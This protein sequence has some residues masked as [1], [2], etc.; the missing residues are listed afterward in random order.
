[1]DVCQNIVG[2]PSG[3][4]SLKALI[5][6]WGDGNG[7]FHNIFMENTNGDV[8]KSPMG[9]AGD[10]GWQELTTGIIHVSDRQLLIGGQ[11]DYNAHYTGFR[12]LFYGEEPPVESLIKQEI[13]EVKEASESLT[14]EGD[15]TSARLLTPLKTSRSTEVIWMKHVST[16]KP[17]P[18]S[19]IIS[20]LLT[21]MHQPP[22]L[23][24]ISQQMQM[25]SLLLLRRLF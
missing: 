24:A 1:M 14:F 17:L 8:M 5:R 12:L 18:R 20:R 2:L 9:T 13:A 15:S 7:N 4:Y 10:S 25:L 16:S 3:Y 21:L 6:G 22:V 11:S 19:M 23:P